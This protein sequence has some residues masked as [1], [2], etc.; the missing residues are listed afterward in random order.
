MKMYQNKMKIAALLPKHN[1]LLA[2]LYIGR[3]IVLKSMVNNASMLGAIPGIESV[4]TLLTE[5]C[6]RQHIPI[7]LFIKQIPFIAF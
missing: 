4:F 3:N 5:R 6:I 2:P 1:S 7:L